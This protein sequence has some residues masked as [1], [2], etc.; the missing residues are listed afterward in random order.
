M[1]K[2]EKVMKLMKFFAFAAIAAMSF[3]VL[4]DAGNH[5]LSFSTPG[6]DKYADG[7]TVLD[8]E[9]YA[10]V[11]SADGVFEGLTPSCEAIDANDLVVI[12]APLA[13]DGKCPYTVFQIDSKSPKYKGNGV[14][15]VY[16]LD[17]RNADKTAVAAKVDGKPASVNGV[18]A[19]Q[20]YTA[21][22]AEEGGASAKASETSAWGASDY[23]A[24]DAEL[25]QPKIA[26]IA[27]EGAK[28]RITVEDLLPAVKYNIRMGATPEVI[29]T[30]ALETP[31][32]GVSAANFEIDAGDAKFFRVVREPL[33]KEV[34]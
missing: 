23:A 18:L 2:K 9:W 28:V 24:G 6:P 25:K 27:V 4:A 30:Y 22:A 17:T 20:A 33:V 3:G 8:G 13:K 32:T 1:G 26:A 19:E 21:V 10:L 7:A 31:A 14:Y 29:E 5:L 11:W 34:K 15:S 12:V 16:L